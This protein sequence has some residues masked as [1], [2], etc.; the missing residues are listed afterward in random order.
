MPNLY[1]RFRLRQPRD[2][3]LAVPFGQ[4][5]PPR[6]DG[7]MNALRAAGLRPVTSDG[8]PIV[9]GIG[10]RNLIVAT[11]HHRKGNPLAPLAAIQV[12]AIIDGSG[13]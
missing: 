3:L 7:E 4:S 5:H 8:R 6:C 12:A 1:S 10:P 13:K 2:P 9:G 11:G